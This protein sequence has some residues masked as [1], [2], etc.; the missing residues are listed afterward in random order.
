MIE[1]ENSVCVAS[2]IGLKKADSSNINLRA[3]L[4]KVTKN[5]ET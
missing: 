3:L 2:K 1:S 5:S 4:C